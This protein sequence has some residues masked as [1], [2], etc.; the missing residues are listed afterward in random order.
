MKKHLGKWWEILHSADSETAYDTQ[1]PLESL[2]LNLI[3]FGLIKTESTMSLWPDQK[4]VLKLTLLK[5]SSNRF[6]VKLNL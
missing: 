3:G 4:S 1:R 2:A 5:S 6:H